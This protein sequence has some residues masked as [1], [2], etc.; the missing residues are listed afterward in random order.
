MEISNLMYVL[1]TDNFAR[2]YRPI[3]LFSNETPSVVERNRIYIIHSAKK[4]QASKGPVFGHFMT[5]DTIIT[6]KSRHQKKAVVFDSYGWHLK[7]LALLKKLQK[8]G[9]SVEFNHKR[10]QWNN[11]NCAY[12]SLY[13]LLLRSRKHSLKAISKGKFGSD[14]HCWSAIRHMIDNLLPHHE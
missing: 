1:E 6:E 13:F 10:Y 9:F 3:F 12:L 2:Q 11:Q 4:E 14:R 8:T 7:N 5:I